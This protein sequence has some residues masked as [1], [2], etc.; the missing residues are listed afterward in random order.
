LNKEKAWKEFR[1]E[2]LKRAV[3]QKKKL[4]ADIAANKFG[5][6]LYSKNSISKYWI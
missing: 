1:R 2:D 3:E 4:L 5:E 6:F